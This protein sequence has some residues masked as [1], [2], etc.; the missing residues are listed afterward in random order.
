MIF[1]KFMIVMTLRVPVKGI[2]L[3]AKLVWESGTNPSLKKNAAKKRD[4]A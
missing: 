2:S 3:Q 1:F 4:P